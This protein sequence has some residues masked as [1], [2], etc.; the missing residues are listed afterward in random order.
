MLDFWG[1]G[2]YPH[3]SRPVANAYLD[4]LSKIMDFELVKTE[5]VKNFTK[6]NLA[7]YKVV[8]LNNSTEL[9]KILDTTQRI[10]LMDFM[11]VKGVVA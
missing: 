5:D 2:G 7:Q 9:G 8:V 10:A 1:V 3:T 4:S 6:E 11:K